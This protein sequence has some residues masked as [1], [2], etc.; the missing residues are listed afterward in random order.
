MG[1]MMRVVEVPGDAIDDEPDA[2]TTDELAI[3]TWDLDKLY[4]AVD[5]LRDAYAQDHD[6]ED[7]DGPA[8]HWFLDGYQEDGPALADPKL[9]RKMAKEIAKLDDDALEAVG[10]D[11]SD[12]AELRELAATFLAVAKRRNGL[13]AIVE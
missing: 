4:L 6:E 13:V 12:R 7:E 9:L 3:Q 10:V 11:A 5:R 2:E 8:F 1:V